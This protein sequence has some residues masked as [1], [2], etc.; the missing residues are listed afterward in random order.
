[1][2]DFGVARLV[3]GDAGE[4]VFGLEILKANVPNERAE[5]FDGIDFIA[6]RANEPEANIFVGILWK[7]SF[8][9][10]GASPR[11]ASLTTK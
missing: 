1:M 9:I 11:S 5:R 4:F 2:A 6:L 3:P 7:T 8:A 10:G